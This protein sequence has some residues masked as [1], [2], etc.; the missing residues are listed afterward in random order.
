SGIEAFNRHRNNRYLPMN[1]QNRGPLFEDLRGAV[2]R[3]LA[4]GIQNENTT[5][6]Q[7]ESTRPH[8]GNQVSIRIDDHYTQPV[9]QA[10]HEARAE[11]LAG[12]YGKG[13]A[14]QR[15]GKHAGEDE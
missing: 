2:D 13:V 15:P 8:G 9:R 6:P 4:L 3:A 1:G 11:N 10:T 14:E 12:P 7:T 5:V